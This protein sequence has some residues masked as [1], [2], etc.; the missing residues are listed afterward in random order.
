M[1]DYIYTVLTKRSSDRVIKT[2]IVFL[3]VKPSNSAS[4]SGAIY[5]G[6]YVYFEKKKGGRGGEF[7]KKKK[8]SARVVVSA[9]C[10]RVRVLGSRNHIQA[11]GPEVHTY[12][13]LG[14]GKPGGLAN[15]VN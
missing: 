12:G 2:T 7:R 8:I 4:A 5:I 9:G 15:G 1:K 6:I 3:T 10:D 14:S 11:H 13:G